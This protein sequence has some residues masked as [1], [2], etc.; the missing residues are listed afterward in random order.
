MR[1]LTRW[2][3]AMVLGAGSLLTI[4][5]GR[6]RTMP[7]TAPLETIPRVMAGHQSVDRVIGEEERRVTGMSSY[8][9]R[10]FYTD[11]LEEFSVY[12]GYYERQAQ[13]R[14]IHSPKNCLPG[15]GWEVLGA[16]RATVPTARGEVTVNRYELAREGRRALVFYWYQGRGR[17]EASEYA[18]KWELLRD[19]A[20]RRRSEEALVRIVVNIDDDTDDLEATRIATEVAG[21]LIPAV[22]TV[23][24]S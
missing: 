13:G 11:S 16:S 1:K 7:L 18:V 6:Q 3:P 24:P 12:V 17:V 20:L 4:G 10:Q 5:L 21:Q 8:V 19:S 9:M 22:Y 14:T 15:S 2:L 23:L